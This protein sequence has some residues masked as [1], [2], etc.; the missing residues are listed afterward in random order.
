MVR[1]LRYYHAILRSEGVWTVKPY[2]PVTEKLGELSAFFD[3]SPN[4]DDALLL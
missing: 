3:S 2:P 4:D 1:A